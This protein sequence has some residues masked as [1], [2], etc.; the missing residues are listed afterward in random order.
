M[1]IYKTTNLINGKIY[2][3]QDVHNNPKYLGSGKLL[4]KAIRKYGIENFTKQI[5]EE[6]L[7]S[8]ELDKRE[9]FWIKEL[10]AQDLDIGYNL[11]PGGRGMSDETRSKIRE[12][13]KLQTFDK[14]HDEMSARLKGEGNPM[15]GKGYKLEG[16]KNGR[17]GGKG[18]TDMT[19]KKLSE[20]AK[21]PKDTP[22]WKEALKTCRKGE[23]NSRSG[24]TLLEQWEEKYGKEKADILYEEWRLKVGKKGVPKSESMKAKVRETAAKRN[25]ILIEKVQA[26]EILSFESL[27]IIISKTLGASK[28]W[29]KNYMP[30][31][32]ES[33]N[34]QR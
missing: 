20:A 28:L 23:K 29:S 22:N 4:G 7:D 3:G 26:H 33:I 9:I 10:R 11:A 6:C 5:L 13:R 17:Y 14:F 2:V 15:Y 16:E 32:Y 19:R 30:E 31:L 34:S 18:T 8:T 12:K 24:T 1:I 27:A 25:R 21:R